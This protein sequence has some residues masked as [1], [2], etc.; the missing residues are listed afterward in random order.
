MALGARRFDVLRLVLVQAAKL[1]LS[2][3]AIGVLLALVMARGL[4]SLIYDV[5]PADPM[6]F[7]VI[8][9]GVIAVAL[10]ACYIRRAR[11]RRRIR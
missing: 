2:G 8:G 6:T 7:M 9:F 5:S 3:T 1:I 4:K 10:F 11:L